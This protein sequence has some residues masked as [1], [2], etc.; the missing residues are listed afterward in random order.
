MTSKRM[1]CVDCLMKLFATIVQAKAHGW[2]VWVGG[3]RCKGCVDAGKG[4]QAA[5]TKKGGP[6]CQERY[7]A[8]REARCGYLEGHDGQH[9]VVWAGQPRRWGS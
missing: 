6:W 3:A 2:A 7:A 4:H 9:F 5:D 1:V 8:P